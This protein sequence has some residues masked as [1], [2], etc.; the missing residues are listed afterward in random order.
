MGETEGPSEPT[1]A[2]GPG[3]IVADVVFRN[4]THQYAGRTFI[5]DDNVEDRIGFIA[6]LGFRNIGDGLSRL[7]RA[8]WL[9]RDPEIL[10]GFVSTEV[11]E[12]DLGDFLTHAGARTGIGKARQHGI[13]RP[14]L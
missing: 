12:A 11:I 9:N 4:V 3:D 7:G 5:R 14:F 13:H 6:V 8:M 1:V 2:V 10:P